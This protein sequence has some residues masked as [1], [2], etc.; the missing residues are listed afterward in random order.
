[1]PSIA[2]NYTFESSTV[3][4]RVKVSRDAPSSWWGYIGAVPY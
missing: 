2:R 1:M 4:C 3:F